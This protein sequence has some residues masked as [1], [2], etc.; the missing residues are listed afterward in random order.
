MVSK[1]FR[2]F[3]VLGVVG[4][5][6]VSSLAIAFN[7]NFLGALGSGQNWLSGWSYR[8]S[9][10]INGTGTVAGTNYPEEIN[11]YYANQTTTCSVTSETPLIS[12]GQYGLADFPA[13]VYNNKI[14]TF[15]G[16]SYPTY[17]CS[18]YYVYCYDP[19]TN[20]WSLL[21]P[22]TYARWGDAAVIYNGLIYVFGGV[23]ASY[24]PVLPVE[25]YN[26]SNDSW[27]VKSNVPSG[28]ASS[29]GVMAVTV[30]N[31][32]YLFLHQS[33]YRYDPSSDTYTALTNVPVSVEWGTCAY[34]NVGGEDRIYILGG[35][36]GNYNTVYYYRP[37]YNDW[38]LVSTNTPYPAYGVIRDDPVINGKIYYGYG[39][40]QSSSFFYASMYAYDPVANTW[41]QLLATGQHPRDGVACGVVNGSLYVIGGRDSESQPIPGVNYTE[42]FNPNVQNAVVDGGQNV[43]VN[44]NC[45]TDFGDIRFTASDGSTQL[46][47]EMQSS[48]PGVV[49]VFWVKMAD[50][51]TSASSTIYIYYGNPSATT[52]SNGTA[53]WTLFDDF[54]GVNP[55]SNYN[56]E[57][58]SNS[59]F[60]ISTINGNHVLNYT[61]NA[62]HWFLFSRTT[63]SF[64]NMRIV[65]N[66]MPM[67]VAGD[68]TPNHYT[69]ISF[70]ETS[71]STWY[72][73]WI[74]TDA[75][76]Y[77]GAGPGSRIDWIK[78]VGGS[79]SL[80]QTT[81]TANFNAVWSTLETDIAGSSGLV[82]VNGNNVIN[83]T[84]T[85]ITSAG[86]VGLMGYS[87]QAVQYYWDNLCVGSYVNPEPAQGGWGPEELS[88][89]TLTIS[90]FGTGIV[91]LN[92]T[93]PY[94][95]GDVVQLSAVPSVGWSFGSWSGGLSG[96]ANP[97]TLTITGNMAVN[98]TFTQNVYALTTS[99]VGNGS[100]SLNNT[101]PYHY[102]DVVQLSA[103]P[104][105][106]WT[107]DHWTGDLSGSVNP[108]LLTVTGNMN[109]TAYFVLPQLYI[110]P[111][112]IQKGSGD[113]YTTFQTSV[114]VN[115]ISDLKAFD[116]NL[117]WDNNLL[118]LTNV[119]F[120]TAL[121]SIW[122]S[123]DWYLAYN[124]TG[125]GY[126]ELAAVST[127][128][129]FTSTA[130]TS[131]ATLTFIV[132]AAVGE[133]SIHFA[134]VKLS[135]SQ[136]NNIQAEVTDG[137]YTATGPQ[138]LPVLQMG[139][140]SVTCRKYGE[141]FTVQ[142]NVTNAITLDGFNFTIYYSPTLVNYVSVS[143][144]QLGSGTITNVD[145][146]NGVL[147]GYVV[148][149]AISG[150]CWL[151]NITFQDVATMIWKQGQVN[152]L[153]GQVWFH[154]ASLSFSGVQ[155]L[156]YQEGG[157]GQISVNNV[158]FAF[159]PIQGDINNDGVVNILDLRTVAA[160]FDVK[161]GDLLWSAAS[162][163]DL[164]GN[165]VIDIYDLVLIGANFGYTYP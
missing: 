25:A 74:A 58:G 59:Y 117:T 77:V 11:V 35:E 20:S 65:C 4:L 56:N 61:A 157:L 135:D 10:V 120:N 22:M 88:G 70:R 69:G 37:A 108:A 163:Y 57:L 46:S 15:G 30:G 72:F 95:F 31:Y 133:T 28:L 66:I 124:V 98:A 140:G 80:V 84:D 21:A 154:Y 13:V 38:T 8:K 141:S 139:P 142:V 130:A 86:K 129:S 76:G 6:L 161:Q 62:A 138:Y 92:N 134:L 83:A 93:G 50:N 7:L 54:E 85:A 29:D 87:D 48:T 53:V 2:R 107:F 89:Y 126:Y 109:A 152:E 158:A 144:G 97:A 153:D 131:L 40:S 106:G 27:T 105:T 12:W 91:D 132:K 60:S 19:S 160:Y 81:P 18:V 146:T 125:V 114:I 145:Q 36:P 115:K 100:V 41:S 165:G 26:V 123:G 71:S 112:S 128:T 44:G 110:D 23:T 116:F 122:G 55:L 155:Q 45:R 24:S 149:T 101:G 102:G 104:A 42:C 3:F 148:G 127:S 96:S 162:V 17:N 33:S 34:V 78:R 164:N 43:T 16:Y 159:V 121:D 39:N 49:A 32:V 64:Q 113:T 150:N 51:L 82:Y 99:T 79:D 52:T 73:T 68:S 14:Y 9:H 137:S 136:A 67:L 47:Y 143:W 63:S 103:V 5:L 156:V 94:H 90:T 1:R 75:G 118:A 111:S 151:L 119:D 147:E